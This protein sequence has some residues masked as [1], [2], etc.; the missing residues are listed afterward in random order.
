[1]G[2]TMRQYFV[3]L[4]LIFGLTNIAH[5]APD[6]GTLAQFS[7]PSIDGGTLDL[8]Q[9]KGKTVLIVNTASQCGFTPQYEGLQSLWEEYQGRGLVVLGI[10][11][12]DFGTQEPGIKDEIKEFC[13]VNFDI[14]FPMSDKLV[15]KGDEAHPLYQWLRAEL[16]NG[17]RP[18]WNFY[19][20]LINAEGKPVTYFSSMTKPTSSRM[21]K[22][23][24]ANLVN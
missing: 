2:F 6:S 8:A 23:I 11:S 4:S 21:R 18:K 1:M 22:A 20:Y 17:S 16:G 24:E 15:V 19:K 3:I 12:N 5:A 10:P 13:S 7:L 9:F 14:D